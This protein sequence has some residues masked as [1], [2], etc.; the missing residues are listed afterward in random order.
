MR[1]R[2][3]SGGEHRLKYRRGRLPRAGAGVSA[4]AQLP[5]EDLDREILVV[6]PILVVARPRSLLTGARRTFA[7]RPGYELTE[8]VRQAILE[9]PDTTWGARCQ[10][11]RGVQ[12][13]DADGK[14]PCESRHR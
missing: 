7:S 8:T 10:T 14:E 6:P 3:P 1:W 2:R 9:L 11:L 12:A 4:P 13:I 5:A